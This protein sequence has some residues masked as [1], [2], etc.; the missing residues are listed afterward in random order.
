MSILHDVLQEEWDRVRQ[1]AA[2]YQEELALLPKGSLTYKMIRGKAQPYLQWREGDKIKSRYVKRAEL[3]DLEKSLERR[4]EL[5]KAIK[6]MEADQKSLEK[7]LKPE[8]EWR[9]MDIKKIDHYNSILK[10]QRPP[11]AE[12]LQQLQ[13][14]YRLNL[15][16][17]SNALE[18]NTLTLSET[19]IVLEDGLTVAGKPL[20]DYYEAAGH[21]EAFDKMYELAGKDTPALTE[22]NICLLHRLFYSKVDEK[23]AGK[24]RT[25][26]NYISG[27]EYIPPAPEEVPG[28][29]KELELWAREVKETLHPV[30]F[31]AKAHRMLVDIHP[32]LDGNGRT[33]RLL[34]NLILLKA[35]Y[36][37]VCISPAL[38]KE[39]IE[40]LQVAQRADAP[41]DTP[42]IDLIAECEMESLRD[43]FRLFKI[44]FPAR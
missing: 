7:V 24:Y 13:A 38:R 3:A 22:E 16:Y 25:I 12:E 9:R 18:G 36:P 41:S 43:R 32:F 19:K 23:Q 35:G 33:A 28:K 31:A 1:L 30:I 14:Y 4:K 17:S 29:I 27:T 44:P 40:A 26:Q 10:E 6:R 11:S 2:I 8:K 20:K 39:Y 37:I 15:T 21:A 5:Q 42:F 34:M